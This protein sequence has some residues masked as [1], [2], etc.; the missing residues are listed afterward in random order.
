MS[1][2]DF[3]D[4]VAF[5]DKMAQTAWLSGVHDRL[6]RWSGDWKGQSILDVGCGTGRLLL[7]GADEAERLVGVDLSSEMIKTARH[8]LGNNAELFVG[9]AYELPLDDD[10]FDISVSTC[11]MFLLP[12][13]EK[14]VSEMARVTKAGGTL[15]MLN[16]GERMERENVEAY[17]RNHGVE[18]FEKEAFLKWSDVSKRRH[19]YT[20]EQ[21][22]TMLHDHGIK[23]VEHHEVLDGLALV[24]VGHQ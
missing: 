18:G 23:T 10:T 1:E 2:A 5:F 17:C 20:A 3:N 9:D 4:M 24:T 6:K 11:V 15:A 7:R 22:S 21:L 14:G 13:P 19:R 12:E 16:P 8:N